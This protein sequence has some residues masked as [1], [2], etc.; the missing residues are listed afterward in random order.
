MMLIRDGAGETVAFP[1]VDGRPLG[2]RGPGDSVVEEAEKSLTIEHARQGA[3]HLAERPLVVRARS[4]D[5]AIQHLAS[6][7]PDEG[8]ED[9]HDHDRTEH[10][11]ELTRVEM[12]EELGPHEGEKERHG[13]KG[14]HD[15]DDEREATVD[16]EP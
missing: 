1:E 5:V 12:V 11:H 13:G 10:G 8:D 16:D 2:G 14:D 7:V 9:A 15:R 4:I 6:R 3:A